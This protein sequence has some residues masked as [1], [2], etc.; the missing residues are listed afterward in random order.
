MSAVT[1]TTRTSTSTVSRRPP[2]TVLTAV[3]LTVLLT[4][5][6]GYGA[7]YFSGME[8]FSDM[9]LT[10]LVAIEFITGLGLVSALALAGRRALG[11]VGLITYGVWM[12]LFTLF[13]VAYIREVEAIPFGVVGLAVLALALAPATRRW[14]ER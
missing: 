11:R 8:G 6:S 10:F 13:K 2:A 9:D 12:T 4:L 3:P 5:V 7:V 1:A 14:V